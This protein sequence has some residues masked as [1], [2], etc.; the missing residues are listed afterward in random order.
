[1]HIPFDVECFRFPQANI[2]DVHGL[3]MF[4]VGGIQ[5]HEKWNIPRC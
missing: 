4:N 1:M 2:S 3:Q 5:M